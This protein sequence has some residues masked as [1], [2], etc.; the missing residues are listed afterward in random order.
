ME[1]SNLPPFYIG[2]KVVYVGVHKEL[3]DAVYTVLGVITYE[4]GCHSVD[5]GLKNHSLY[6]IISCSC[7][8]KNCV[9]KAER[10]IRYFKHTSLRPIEQQ[11]LP[12]MTF[13]EIRVKEQE[14]VLIDN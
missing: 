9:P 6:S 4:C 3:K 5:I 11:K 14:H 13:K 12:L 7:P 2:Q 8:L 1:K 10:N